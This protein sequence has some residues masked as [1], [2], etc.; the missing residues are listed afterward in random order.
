MKVQQGDCVRKTFSPSVSHRSRGFLQTSVNGNFQPFRDIFPDFGL[1]CKCFVD[2][3]RGRE[4]LHSS[5]RLTSTVDNTKLSSL[6]NCCSCTK[7]FQFN[8]NLTFSTFFLFPRLLS[9]LSV[10]VMM[11]GSTFIYVRDEGARVQGSFTVN[12]CQIPLVAFFFFFA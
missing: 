12:G 8:G 1:I 11:S 6:F 7:K 5:Q 3:L 4:R 2:L 9:V 10:V